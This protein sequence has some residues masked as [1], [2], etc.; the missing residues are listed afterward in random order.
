[1][2]YSARRGFTNGK[3]SGAQRQAEMQAKIQQMQEQMN[4]AQEAVEAQE[5]T[6]SVG[7]GVVEAKVNGK[8]EVLS[9]T[10][11]PEAVDPE[12][13]E[14]LQDLVVSAVNEALRQ[15]GEAMEKSMSGVTGGLDLGALTTHRDIELWDIIKEHYPAMF[16]GCSRV[17]SVQIRTRGTLGGNICN[18][19]PSA[20]S[21]GP[22]LVHDARVV[23]TGLNGAREV[24]LKEFYLGLKKLDMGP[25]ELLTRIRIPTPRSIGSPECWRRA[26]IRC[27]LRAGLCVLPPKM[28]V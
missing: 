18:G 8:K 19:A 13:V 27:M 4:A 16:E 5:F 23:V 14:M 1:M 15:A 21:I 22:M 10:I 12:D 7:G 26:R 3:V 6:A 28:W 25:D 11:K 24:P 17:G 9:V 20:D 2:G